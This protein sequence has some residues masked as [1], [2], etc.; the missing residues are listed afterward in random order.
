[1]LIILT[2]GCFPSLTFAKTI[3]IKA[4]SYENCIVDGN[5]VYCIVANSIWKV[6]LK[7]AAVRK[8][9]SVGTSKSEISAL[10][11]KGGYL[12][13][14]RS[15]HSDDNLWNQK[16][17]IFR[18]KKSGKSKKKLTPAISNTTNLTYSVKGKKIYYTWQAESDKK[19]V[20]VYKKKMNLNGTGRENTK[21]K[22]KYT[23]KRSNKKGYKVYGNYDEY[24][25][26]AESLNYLQTP[27][28][29]YFINKTRID[30]K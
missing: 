25:T 15:D 27:K 13:F 9:T 11:M 20:K 2:M 17:W 14:V 8:V 5:N 4:T 16:R 10:G 24:K 22:V 29:S 7:S 23:Y 3:A 21:T 12:Y 6:N 18:V 19:S 1:M 26:Y 28:R 30:Y